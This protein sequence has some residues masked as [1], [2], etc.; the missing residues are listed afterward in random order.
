MQI[1]SREFIYSQTQFLNTLTETRVVLSVPGLFLFI[2]VLFC[3]LIIGIHMY[4][5]NYIIWQMNKLLSP[6]FLNNS[7]FS[8]TANNLFIYFFILTQFSDS[9][10]IT[11]V[12]RQMNNNNALQ[13]NSLS[14]VW[15][16]FFDYLSVNPSL[17]I[18]L[19]QHRRKEKNLSQ[20]CRS[21]HI[22]VKD[23]W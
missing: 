4:A 6:F 12:E 21:Y 15:I 3:L 18:S 17:S 9:S 23:F 10:L 8:H 2:F 19:Y 5:Y 11:R 7:L 14:C 22:I 13:L 20:Q 1:I 16:F